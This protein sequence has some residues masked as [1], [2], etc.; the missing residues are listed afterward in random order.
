MDEIYNSLES[1]NAIA[2]SMADK[3]YKQMERIVWLK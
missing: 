1:W 2:N 3:K